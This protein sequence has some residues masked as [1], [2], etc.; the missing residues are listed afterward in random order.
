M[1]CRLCRVSLGEQVPAALGAEGT[2]GGGGASAGAA[3]AAVPGGVVA[4]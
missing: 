3:G 2:A 4:G 1:R